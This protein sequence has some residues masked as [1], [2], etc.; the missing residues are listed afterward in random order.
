MIEVLVT[1]VIVSLGLLGFAGLQMHSLKSNATALHRSYATML[2]YDIADCMRVNRAAAIA[3]NYNLDF[4]TAATSGTVQGDD[5]V[6]WKAA[7]ASSL[8]NGQ[9]KITVNAQGD[10]QIE[11]R[12][13][14]N[15]NSNRTLTFITQ[16]SL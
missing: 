14:E 1:I 15:I 11:V 12:W 4:A 8:P 16:T 5:M 7:L 13:A 10:V 6:T 3:G 9:G 2:A